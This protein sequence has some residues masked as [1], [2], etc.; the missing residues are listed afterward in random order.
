VGRAARAVEDLLADSVRTRRWSR[1]W[2][3]L[4]AIDRDA[5]APFLLTMA[6]RRASAA[7]DLSRLRD[8]LSVAVELGIT[9]G[10][11]VRQG[12]GLLRRATLLARDVATARRPSDVA[13]A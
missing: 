2:A 3:E 7:G 8:C 11:A 12:V 1:R 9:D 5:L 6:I 10:P 13:L 4:D